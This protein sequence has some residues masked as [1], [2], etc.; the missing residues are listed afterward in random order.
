MRCYFRGALG[1]HLYAYCVVPT[2]KYVKNHYMRNRQAC[3]L[4]SAEQ[5]FRCCHNIAPHLRYA[6][7]FLFC[8][9]YRTVHLQFPY[10]YSLNAPL[11]KVENAAEA[12]YNCYNC[13][14]PA[15]RQIGRRIAGYTP[16]SGAFAQ[17]RRRG[18]AAR[19][20]GRSRSSSPA[21]GRSA[22]RARS[23]RVL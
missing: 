14:I 7:D 3:S 10:K 6:A 12:G 21:A 4:Q 15:P 1:L 20:G 18:R 5:L 16:R 17:C 8:R 11:K 9:Q 19:C 23:S 2:G 13:F 22:A